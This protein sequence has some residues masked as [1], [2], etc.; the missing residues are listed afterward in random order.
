MRV[1]VTGGAGYI[2]SILSKMLVE[3]GYQVR[4]LDRFFFGKE[5]ISDISG[6][7][8]LVRDDI[9]WV[10]SGVLEGVDA[11]IDLAALSNDPTG[12]LD[13]ELTLEINYRG[14]A[15]IAKMA[16][17]ARVKKYILASSTS[18]YGF[19][20]EVVSEQSEVNPLTTYAKANIL[21][22][23]EVLP[24]ASKDFSVTALRQSSCFGA[25]KRMR[26]DISLNNM[27]LNI[28]NKKKIPVMRDGNQK[29]P[30][31]HV[32][33]TSRAF[34]TVLEADHEKVSGQVFNAGSDEQNFK[35]FDLG[36]L[37][38]DSLDLP[39]DFEWYGY[40]DFRS[41]SVSF[42]KIKTILNYEIKYPPNVGA[43][44]IFESL[45]N[46]EISSDMKTITLEWYKHLIKVHE[47]DQQVA[48]N[49]KIL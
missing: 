2:G 23:T 20:N 14:R 34:M 41:Y 9:R 43:K 11:V 13:P 47:L 10:D 31:I 36:K 27:V 32:K 17:K 46:G 7:V 40:P 6:G 18:V 24:L 19:Q 4:I 22:E 25:S 49:G 26:F 45:N 39:F 37:A 48:L 15:R 38:A 28:F 29:R 5:P 1:L 35:L 44:E 3:R 21:A 12:E 8:E 16:Q 42:K 30:I 33:D